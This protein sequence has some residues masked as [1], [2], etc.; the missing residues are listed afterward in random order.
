M[1]SWNEIKIEIDRSKE[2]HKIEKKI[3]TEFNSEIINFLI[4]NC[5]EYKIWEII[6]REETNKK[7]QSSSCSSR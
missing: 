5:K 1:A 6:S 4:K 3:M 2:N 7:I